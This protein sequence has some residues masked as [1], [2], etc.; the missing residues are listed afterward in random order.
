[1]MMK[2]TRYFVLLVV[3]FVATQYIQAQT[4]RFPAYQ[5]A[6][7]ALT[8]D[9]E[10]DTVN[11]HMA[12][13]AHCLCDKVFSYS[14]HG[15]QPSD[16]DSRIIALTGG[17]ANPTQGTTLPATLCRLLQAY[18]Q[19]DL[20]AIKQQYSPSDATVFD[21]LLSNDTIRQSYLSYVG[22]IQHMKL[23]LTFESGD[24]TIAFVRCYTN[25]PKL[26]FLPFIMQ[27]INNRWYATIGTDSSSIVSN[28]L[29]FLFKK[30]F[31]NLLTG[32]DFDGDGVVDS[33]DNCPCRVNPD[34]AD[35]DGDGVGD[36]C[37]NC[38]AKAN[39]KQEDFDKDGRG[40]VCDN[41]PYR[42]NFDQ[43]DS[44]GDGLG[45][46][47]DN[48]MFIPN[49]RQFD[50]DYDGVGNECDD[51]IDND[52][53]PND[54]D[55]DMDGD[56]VPNHVDNCPYHYNPG[57]DDSD[58]DGLGDVCDNC[59]LRY[60]PGQE[61]TDYDGVGDVCDKDRDGDGVADSEDNCPDTPNPDQNDTDCDGLGD[62]CD[63]DRDGDTI[64]NEL[65]N[66]PDM[67]NPDQTD[68]NSN[69]IGDVCE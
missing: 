44:D 37:D 16:D 30:P 7:Y 34:Q 40:D 19:G 10:M 36:V 18:H 58:G 56:D 60:N 54:Q 53:I 31:Q 1:M 14:V 23:L 43:V 55:E 9:M 66:C 2:K 21:R 25:T 32:S 24:K 57:Q 35:Q 8:L 29:M 51:D 68:S 49:P 4:C 67:F 20:A 63:P 42:P 41:C 69:G 26:D 62:V 33:L 64:P 65:D 15:L 6:N 11:F 50:F 52:G 13:S 22:Q 28:V 27:K 46:S 61:D 39:P 5:P 47:C 48:C 12:D 3:V 38:P 17:T 59:P 45:D